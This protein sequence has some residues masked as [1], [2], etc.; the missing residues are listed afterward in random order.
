MAVNGGRLILEMKK[1]LPYDQVFLLF[2]KGLERDF[3]FHIH[4]FARHIRLN[5][6]L[7]GVI[8]MC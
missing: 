2:F 1:S 5:I 3:A 8:A 7:D 4:P 6:A